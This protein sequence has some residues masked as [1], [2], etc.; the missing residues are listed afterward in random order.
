[1]KKLTATVA[2]CVLGIACLNAQQR[3]F[4]IEGMV[5]GAD[6]RYVYL[7]STVKGSRDSALVENGKFSYEGK[8]AYPDFF[9]V[10]IP[11]KKVVAFFFY[12]GTVNLNEVKPDSVAVS[13]DGAAEW[14]AY[15]DQMAPLMQRMQLNRSRVGKAK[16]GDERQQLIAEYNELDSLIRVAKDDYIRRHSNTDLSAFLISQMYPNKMVTPEIISLYNTLGND[17][18]Q[19]EYGKG[20]K[21]DIDLNAKVGAGSI[22]PAFTVVDKD[23]KK[24]SLSDYK[25][26]YVLLDFWGSWCGPCRAS[27]PHLVQLYNKYKGDKFDILGLAGKETKREKWLE[28]IVTDKLAWPQANLKENEATQNIVQLYVILGYPTKILINPQGIIIARSVGKSDEIDAKLKEV[29][30]K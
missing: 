12:G 26:K 9:Y 29:F 22:A 5:S 19:S 21:E 28:A 27:H 13:G 7:N 14:Y 1:M 24:I 8:L 10:R 2:L 11:E 20:I 3:S 15:S 23:G 17:A 18:K 25:G 30:G 4:K 6:N 16:A